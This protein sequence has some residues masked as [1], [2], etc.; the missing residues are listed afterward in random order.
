MSSIFWALPVDYQWMLSLSE[1]SRGMNPASFTS[2]RSFYWRNF[3]FKGFIGAFL[4]FT[5]ISD[6]FQQWR[7]QLVPST[8]ECMYLLLLL[9][10]LSA[11]WCC[12]GSAWSVR[13]PGTCRSS[14]VH[15]LGVFNVQY[16]ILFIF[17]LNS[18]T[19]FD[20]ERREQVGFKRARSSRSVR[21]RPW[22]ALKRQAR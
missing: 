9:L 3:L 18:F 20:R 13:R 5:E 21:R 17:L 1:I 4:I 2:P 11:W 16:K 6:S 12:R 22:Q 8:N 19:S 7:N 14:S 10:L 15:K